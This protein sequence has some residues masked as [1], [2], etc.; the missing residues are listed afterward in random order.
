MFINLHDQF[1]IWQ[2]VQLRLLHHNPIF[3]HIAPTQPYRKRTFK[4]MPN[5]I[6]IYLCS[7]I[8]SPFPPTQASYRIMLCNCS[9]KREASQLLKLQCRLLLNNLVLPFPC[10][11]Y[12]IFCTI[13]KWKMDQFNLLDSKIVRLR[14]NEKVLG[15]L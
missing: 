15:M 14:E 9:E 11:S 10:I 13:A 7:L 4:V 3:V 6:N 2:E 1:I 5:S 12:K 8:L